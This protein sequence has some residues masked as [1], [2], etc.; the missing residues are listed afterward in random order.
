MPRC[1]AS[2]TSIAWML[3]IALAFSLA[4]PSTSAAHEAD[5]EHEEEASP[6]PVPVPP[7]RQTT[8]P[9]REQWP[10]P[11]AKERSF[12]GVVLSGGSGYFAPWDSDD[13]GGVVASISLMYQLPRGHWRFGGEFAYRNFDTQFYDV[14][15]VNTNNYQINLI[16]HYV[17]DPGKITPY[18]G[19]GFGVHINDIDG[20]K[21]ERDN[22][23]V[24]IDGDTAAG[25]GF[26]A[27]AGLEVPLSDK[28]AF[29]AEGRVDISYLFIEDNDFFNNN[30]DY[31]DDYDSFNTGG[32]SGLIGVRVRF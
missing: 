3:T 12:G 13:G 4:I 5:W 22:P 11:Y 15:S 19:T 23:T 29:F 14:E 8:P 16:A 1:H 2:L 31:Y 27:L 20:R 7:P 24:R 28:V 25:F 17:F 32:G 26:F 18:V 30:D 6:T 21:I 10:D 9:P